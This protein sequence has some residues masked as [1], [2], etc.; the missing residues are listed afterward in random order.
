M[1]HHPPP[2]A[3]AV[4]AQIAHQAGAVW[5]DGGDDEAWSVLAW[6][7][8]DVHTQASGWPEAGRARSSGPGGSDTLPFTSGCIGYV[9]YE[10]GDAVAPVPPG[11][12]TI[13]PP[14]WLARF[15]GALLFHH[16]TQ[17]WF[18]TGSPGRQ[19]DAA[20][21][22]AGAATL[23]PPP[24]APTPRRVHSMA[25]AAFLDAVRRTQAWIAE[26]D[27]YQLNLSRAVHVQGVDDPWPVYRRLRR[28]SRPGRAA[29]LRLAPDLA[30]LSNSPERLL[31]VQGREA[32]TEPIKGTRPRHADPLDDARAAAE[33]EASPKERAELTMIVDLCRNDLGQVAMPGTV[34]ASER[35]ITAHANVHHASVHIT[36]QL[37]QGRD[38]WDAL[39]AL[40]PPGSVVGAPKVRA[41]T[42][43]RALEPE[44]R[45][46]YCG[47]IGFVSD[48]GTAA[49]SVAI[50]TAILHGDHAR[51][52]VGGGIVADS[53]PEAEW[54]ETVDKGTALAAALGV[55]PADQ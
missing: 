20:A 33:L 54:D 6:D 13:E 5:L 29:F 9:G 36:A 25:R 46:A 2:S 8:S 44:P 49:W 30:V 41:A 10:A 34:R 43:I 4:F 22:L 42:R 37:A 26:G 52:H 39:A 53:V 1:P 23:P 47:A 3:E 11:G 19:R 21:L 50:R 12:R 32:S 24:P 27:H 16:P 48:T 51:Y 45:G 14:V 35:R 55:Q 28:T 15:D 38:A 31:D 7:P 40:F 18:S 17:R